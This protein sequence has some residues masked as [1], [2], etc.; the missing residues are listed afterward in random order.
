MPRMTICSRYPTRHAISRAEGAK[1]IATEPVP[2]DTPRMP[3]R[4]A[5]SVSAGG[6]LAT[7]P[8]WISEFVSALTAKRNRGP[9]ETVPTRTQPNVAAVLDRHRHLSHANIPNF[10]IATN[11]AILGL[12]QN[13]NETESEVQSAACND[14]ARG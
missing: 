11:A 1:G 6:V 3:R 7:R 8:S 13:A 10:G 14:A 12:K 5:R 9:A 2:M 4:A